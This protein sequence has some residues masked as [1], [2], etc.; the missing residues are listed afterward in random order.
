VWFVRILGFGTYDVIR[1]PRVGILLEG[2]ALDGN[3]VVEV[4][5]PLG[6]STR[7]R[8][9]MLH[10]PWLAYRLALRMA[11]AW[12]RLV[13]RAR[14]AG[15]FDAVVVGYLGHFDVV[16]ARVCFPRTTVVLD[17]LVFAADTARDRGVS[18]GLRLRLL[19]LLDAIA[20]SCADLVLVDT[21][22]NVAL[23]APSKRHKA[24]AV[25]VGA[26]SAWFDAGEA[27]EP[28]GP[29]EPLHVVFF[30]LFTPLQG[31]VIIG[32]ALGIL[33]G[34]DGIS[35]TMIGSGQDLAAARTAAAS[36]PSVTWIDWM[37]AS[38]LPVEVSGSDVCLGIFGVTPKALRVVPNK[39]YQGAAAGCCIVTSDTAPQRRGLGPDAV[40]VPAGDA[41]ALALALR[42]L[43]SDRASLDALSTAA[44][45]R[46]LDAF[47][48]RVVASTLAD[49]LAAS[50]R[51]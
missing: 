40:Y 49:R 35:V 6:L 48:P 32:E 20:T 10:K 24:L 18:S 11:A 29:R 31:A 16:L 26:P 15:R 5:E 36:N 13:R 4:N 41:A 9:E 19:E 39:V 45:R 34:D 25:A 27:R 8:V 21:E 42:A 51:G 44:H 46:A 38:E 17:Q 37:E 22:E 1:H 7:E 30:G 12:W 2:L 3:D 23:L 28:R 14:R 33:A 47:T 43:A 50:V